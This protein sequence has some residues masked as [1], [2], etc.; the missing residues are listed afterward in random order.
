MVISNQI[1]SRQV[2]TSNPHALVSLHNR[3]APCL[4]PILCLY[5]VYSIYSEH[6]T[7]NVKSLLWYYNL[8]ANGSPCAFTVKSLKRYTVVLYAEAFLVCTRH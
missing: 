7:G 4:A 1:K 2:P 5:T 6:L 8:S 3:K